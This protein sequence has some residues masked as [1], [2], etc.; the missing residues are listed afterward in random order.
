MVVQEILQVED[1]PDDYV[2]ELFNLKFWPEHPLSFPVCGR[3][4][5][6]QSF[7]QRDFLDFV[8]ARYR[9]DR[10]IIAAAGNLEHEH[11]VEWATQQ[12]GALQGRADVVDGQPPV[13]QR[14]VSL[15]RKGARTG[16]S[17][18]GHPRHLAVGG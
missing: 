1:T 5:T 3:V 2:H 6:V 12:F 9:P 17:L 11:V 14:G 10:L 15:L 13:A 8:A 18:P 4:E 7:A 16:A